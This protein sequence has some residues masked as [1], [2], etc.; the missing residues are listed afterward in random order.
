MFGP[1]WPP[2]AGDR[3]GES[4]V[5]RCQEDD[6]GARQHQSHDNDESH[7]STNVSAFMRGEGVRIGMAPDSDRPAG[8][9]IRCESLCRFDVSPDG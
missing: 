2:L 5:L 4:V 9:R 8:H 6:T 7:E 1:R 3:A